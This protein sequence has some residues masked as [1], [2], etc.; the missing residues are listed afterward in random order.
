MQQCFQLETRIFR[1]LLR[2]YDAGADAQVRCM[3]GGVAQGQP[4]GLKAPR[5]QNFKPNE[6]K[7]RFQLEPRFF[8][9][10][11][12]ATARRGKERARVQQDDGGAAPGSAH[13]NPGPLIGRHCMT[14]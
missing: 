10:A 5:F 7:T 13:H 3:R 9:L 4:R 8:P 12:A 1:D 11:C 14:V 6:E 2:H